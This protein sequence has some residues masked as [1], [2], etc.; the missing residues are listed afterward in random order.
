MLSE[1]I[2]IVVV[3]MLN[4]LLWPQVTAHIAYLVAYQLSKLR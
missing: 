2:H 4:A 1:Y 3:M